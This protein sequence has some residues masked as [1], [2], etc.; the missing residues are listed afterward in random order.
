M[1]IVKKLIYIVVVGWLCGVV[2]LRGDTA[3]TAG[4]I[5]IFYDSLSYDFD[6]FSRYNIEPS[7]YYIANISGFFSARHEFFLFVY[8]LL[9]FGLIYITSRVL[10]AS[11]PFVLL[12]YVATYFVSYQFTLMRQGLGLAFVGLIVVSI[13]H[14]KKIRYILLVFAIGLV[15]GASIHVVSIL[16]LVV[17]A[18]IRLYLLRPCRQ[19]LDDYFTLSIQLFFGSLII[20]LALIDNLETFIAFVGNDKINYYSTSAEYSSRLDYV[21]TGNVKAVL[22]VLL[23]LYLCSIK[24]VTKEVKYLMIASYSIQLGLRLGLI[25]FAIFSGRVGASFSFYDAFLYSIIVQ[26]LKLSIFTKAAIFLALAALGGGWI[27]WFQYPNLIDDY[28]R[29]NGFL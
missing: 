8:S 7:Y 12:F 4:Y 22:G 26:S 20:S 13:Y 18:F 27:F 28:Y 16:P 25:D 15:G 6:Y 23:S 9:S 10:S 24:S 1:N 2:A 17:L 3:D 5:E 21:S 11:F 19:P 29:S 14:S